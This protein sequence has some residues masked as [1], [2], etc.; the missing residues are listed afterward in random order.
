MTF[1][2]QR[3]KQHKEQKAD[4][5][6]QIEH[7]NPGWL[8]FLESE[9]ETLGTIPTNVLSSCLS[10]LVSVVLESTPPVK[11]KQRVWVHNG[12]QWLRKCLL[13]TWKMG[14]AQRPSTVQV[15]WWERQVWSQRAALWDWEIATCY[16]ERRKRESRLWAHYAGMPTSCLPSAQIFPTRHMDPLQ[17][18]FSHGNACLLWQILINAMPSWAVCNHRKQY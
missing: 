1:Q 7:Q 18:F 2:C 8:F 3:A 14:E 10:N 6:K 17:S 13:S 15:T 11:Q 16:S 9:S 5:H 12:N 4:L